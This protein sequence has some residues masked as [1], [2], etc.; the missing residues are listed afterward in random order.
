MSDTKWR[1][2]GDYFETGNFGDLSLDGLGL[3][4]MIPLG[5]LTK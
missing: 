5:S 4:V 2:T 3:A 1:L